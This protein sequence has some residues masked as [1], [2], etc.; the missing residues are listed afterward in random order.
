MTIGSSSPIWQRF[1]AVAGI[2]TEVFG[3]NASAGIPRL[4]VVVIPGNPGSAEYF[5]PFMLSVHRQLQ[6]HADVLA[7]THAGHDPETN[8]GGQLWNLRQQIA[9]KIA[10]L[11]EHVLLPGRPPVLLVGHSI[12]AAMMIKSNS[13]CAGRSADRG[14]VR[15][16]RA[17]AVSPSAAA[18]A[19]AAEGGGGGGEGAGR[20][21]AG[22][23]T[24]GWRP[25]QVSV[26]TRGQPGS[27]P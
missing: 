9:H 5:K 7:V 27:V 11:R 18:E 3:I 10:F 15:S 8:H 20:A 14:A 16:T 23:P 24:G 1:C 17:A 25:Q 12:G 26:G 13:V 2:T 21:G 6:G 19:E 22:G 4:Q